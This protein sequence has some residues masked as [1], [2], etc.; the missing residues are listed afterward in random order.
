MTK[1]RAI[2]A[3]FLVMAAVACNPAY[4]QI[5][6]ADTEQVHDL[7]TV[8][9]GEQPVESTVENGVLYEF[10]MNT[11][12]GT[13]SVLGYPEPETACLIDSGLIALGT[14]V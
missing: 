9:Y 5:A 3:A 2:F 10:W 12:T 6:C 14:S 8:E 11:D 7:L 1:L 13:Y 4:A